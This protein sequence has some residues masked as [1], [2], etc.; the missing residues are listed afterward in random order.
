[1]TFKLPHHRVYTRLICSRIHGVGVAAIR[2]IRKGTYL[3]EPDEGEIVWIRAE[4]IRTLSR[5]VRRLYEDF[6]IK[7]EE[8]YGCPDSF[9]H[10]TPAW[11]LN[12]SSDPNVAA[13]SEYRFYA[14]RNIKPEE[15]LTV[16]Y[17]TYS[18]LQKRKLR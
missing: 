15:E 11:F 4:E 13:D 2:S 8:L 5:E 3:F 10:L 17:G 18:D 7:K 12:H 6:A 16:D 14:T 9:N 1:M